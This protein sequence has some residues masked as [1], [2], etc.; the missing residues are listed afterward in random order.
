VYSG[1]WYRL[2]VHAETPRDSTETTRLKRNTRAFEAEAHRAGLEKTLRMINVN[3]SKLECGGIEFA[4]CDYGE[5]TKRCTDKTYSTALGE[6]LEGSL[7][8]A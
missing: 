4:A 7:P 6:R 3:G 5:Y 2:C 8:V 1:N